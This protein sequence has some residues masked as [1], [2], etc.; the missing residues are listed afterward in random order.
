MM[1]PGRP[2]SRQIGGRNR[3]LSGSTSP[4]IHLSPF[5]TSPS[6]T[7]FPQSSPFSPRERN[8][9]GNILTTEGLQIFPIQ[10]KHIPEEVTMS[11]T[12]GEERGRSQTPSKLPPQTMQSPSPSLAKQVPAQLETN[13]EFIISLEAPH[14]QLEE[15]V[16]SPINVSAMASPIKKKQAENYNAE[17]S[18]IPSGTGVRALKGYANYRNTI[19]AP[20]PPTTTKSEQVSSRTRSNQPTV[21][22]LASINPPTVSTKSKTKSSSKKIDNS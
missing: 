10:T 2:I 9:T 16:R 21:T 18:K 11:A 6:P 4:T 14:E 5:S 15:M 12:Q 19:V 3:S 1:S 13:E 22:T 17:I 8:P 7:L 20:T